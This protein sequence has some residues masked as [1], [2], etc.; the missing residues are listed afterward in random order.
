MR[1]MGTFA[2]SALAAALSL[3]AA[4][5][6]RESVP[7]N[8]SIV[9]AEGPRAAPLGNKNAEDIEFL[10][11]ALRT[12][13]AEID[14]GTLAAERAE[15]PRVREYAGKLATEHRAHAAKLE[16]LLEPLDVTVPEEPSADAQLHRAALARLAGQEFDAAF[17][18]MMIA[19]HSEA[20][21][22]YGAQTHANPDRS[23]AELATE[24]I[25]MLREHLR[26]AESLR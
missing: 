9:V 6:T 13:L 24:S 2:L 21:E 20:I 15:D 1:L 26:I 11:E 8:R 4:A 18:E 14:L 25:P 17:V 23:L 22:R 3:G 19:S 7:E 5:Q 12:S 16:Q 10:V